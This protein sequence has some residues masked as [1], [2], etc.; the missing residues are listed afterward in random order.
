MD[1]R[2]EASDN[3]HNNPP[4]DDMFE[5]MRKMRFRWELWLS[6]VA[7]LLAAGLAI[8]SIVYVQ[9]GRQQVEQQLQQLEEIRGKK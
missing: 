1:R 8:L 5:P 4:T 3:S 6:I 2:R 9:Q 7:M